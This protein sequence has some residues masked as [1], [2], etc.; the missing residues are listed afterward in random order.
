MNSG[1]FHSQRQ[2]NVYLWKIR[3][4]SNDEKILGS[5]MKREMNLNSNNEGAVQ[6]GREDLEIYCRVH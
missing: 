4:V 1:M 6:W 2:L 5:I 3:K